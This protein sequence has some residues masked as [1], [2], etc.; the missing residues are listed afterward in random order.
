MFNS[1]FFSL[2]V[3]SNENNTTITIDI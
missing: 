1:F 2:L 3:F